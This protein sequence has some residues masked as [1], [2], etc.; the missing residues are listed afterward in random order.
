MALRYFLALFG[1]AGAVINVI[2]APELE[3]KETVRA[4]GFS[5]LAVFF[6][7][8]AREPKKE[9]EYKPDLLPPQQLKKKRW[10]F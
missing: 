10:P 9:E 7:L 2:L 5:I 1:L 4:M 6:F 3:S 8:K